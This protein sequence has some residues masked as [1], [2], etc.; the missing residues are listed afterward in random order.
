METIEL[1]YNLNLSHDKKINNVIIADQKDIFEKA[2]EIICKGILYIDLI[3]DDDS[4][5]HKEIDFSFSLNKQKYHMKDVCFELNDYHYQQDEKMCQLNISYLIKGEDVRFDNFCLL[6]ND[7]LENELRSYLSRNNNEQLNS[8]NLD[9]IELLDPIIEE[10]SK[11]V[12]I[13]NTNEVDQTFEI[14]DHEIKKEEILKETYSSSF[15][16]YRIKKGETPFDICKKFNITEYDLLSV[17][18]D[19]DFKENVLIQIKKNV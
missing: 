16:F 8:I 9:K 17:N 3:L 4:C 14:Q 13:N 7:E 1:N 6:Q 18:E 5:D 12:E 11:E 10:E 15:M 2:D 19:K